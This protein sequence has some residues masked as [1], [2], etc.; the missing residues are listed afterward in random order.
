VV[1]LVAQVALGALK[2]LVVA[3]AVAL[4]FFD[5]FYLAN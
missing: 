4:M 5:I 1:V 2:I 3:A